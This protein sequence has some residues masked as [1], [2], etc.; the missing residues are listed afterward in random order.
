M[1][2]IGG[3]HLPFLEEMEISG[4]GILTTGCHGQ[5]VENGASYTMMKLVIGNEK[6][7]NILAENDTIEVKTKHTR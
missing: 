4:I 5:G 2:V 6:L 3:N 7:E 1:R